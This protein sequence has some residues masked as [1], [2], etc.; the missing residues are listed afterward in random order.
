MAIL[1]LV[2]CLGALTTL[3]PFA[4]MM[5]TGFKGPTDQNDNS[6]KP[7]YWSEFATVD[8][9]TK[10]LAPESLM[11]KY[12]FDKYAG[13]AS[14][15]AS[16]RIGADA[17]AEEIE[18]Y[19]KSL[20][21]LPVYAWSAGFRTAPSQS[22]GRLTMRYQAWLRTRYK[23][24]DDLNRAY[25]E[26]N[27]AFQTVQPPTEM[28]ERKAWKAPTHRKYL[29]WL[30]FKATLPAEF[31]IP[32][33]WERLW[34]EFL[35]AKYQN[36]IDQ[37]P[38]DLKGE[39][40]KFEEIRLV[41]GWEKNA[42]RADL[43]MLRPNVKKL[44]EDT[45]LKLSQ[46]TN[47]VLSNNFQ[48][49]I[50]NLKRS[51][52]EIDSQMAS[53]LTPSEIVYGEFRKSLPVWAYDQK[54]ITQPSFPIAAYETAHVKA[55]EGEIKREFATRNYRY[56]FDYVAL[57]GR[58]LWNTAIFC[59]LAILIQLTVNPLAAYALSRYPMKATGKILLFLLATMAFP[60][61]VAMIP[62]FLLLKDL[63]LL[64][65]FAAL[66]LPTAASGYMIFLLKGFFDSLPPEL[67]E[68]GQIDGAKESTMMFKIA[69]PLSRPVF[70][71]MALL[72]FMGAY[73]AFLYAF[74]VAQDQKIWTLMVFIYQLQNTAP[75]SVMMAALT[76]AA[77][78]T[79][80]VFLIAQRAIMRGIIL[81]G[82]K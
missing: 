10:Q 69:F 55:H 43:P 1:Y 34:Q 60:A 70:G 80:L 8:E 14:M 59:L 81:P 68:S 78:P 67:F 48:Q 12:L 39:A 37:V 75:K 58:A 2:L 26:E 36:Q 3:Y 17:S 53:P 50:N 15:I 64:N 52:A 77:L 38:G 35:R 62:S 30:E 54:N 82:E 21:D 19:E 20:M 24:V 74:L 27:S 13:D 32:L 42:H 16:T 33:R 73:G 6:L 4:M 49:N 51:L 11:G 66:V 31:R 25:I 61:E 23:T 76:L 56:V 7:R 41:L 28:L 71:Y 29:E 44:L 18:K 57:N 47:P 63:G 46:T 72:A 79:L 65:T 40:A 5:V 9:K 22:T 45:Q